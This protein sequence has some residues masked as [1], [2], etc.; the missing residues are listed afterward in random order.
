MVLHDSYFILLWA[1]HLVEYFFHVHWLEYSLLFITRAKINKG[2]RDLNAVRPA[3][4]TYMHEGI[5]QVNNIFYD[6][7]W[8]GICVSVLR[9]QFIKKNFNVVQ[10][11]SVNILDWLYFLDFSLVLK[12]KNKT[13]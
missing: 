9:N 4:E 5:K 7:Q 13:W 8:N 11:Q 3:G 12:W 6:K 10:K 1:Y 2:L